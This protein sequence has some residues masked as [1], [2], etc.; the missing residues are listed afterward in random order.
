[1]YCCSSEVGETLFNYL[2]LFFFKKEVEKANMVFNVL[3]ILIQESHMKQPLV[4][5]RGTVAFGQILQPNG[6]HYVKRLTF[7]KR[8]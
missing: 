5:I 7:V 3:D 8:I 2:S 6:S 1:M 4:A